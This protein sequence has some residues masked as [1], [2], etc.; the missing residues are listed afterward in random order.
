MVTATKPATIMACWAMCGG[1]SVVK[2]FHQD[3]FFKSGGAIAKDPI[4]F[5]VDIFGSF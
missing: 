2:S 3:P 4:F 1:G 5:V